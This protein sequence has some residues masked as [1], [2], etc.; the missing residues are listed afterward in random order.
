MGNIGRSLGA[1]MDIGEDPTDDDLVIE[2]V[3]AQEVIA[4]TIVEADIDLQVAAV[5]CAAL[6][7]E[8]TAATAAGRGLLLAPLI[9]EAIG[10]VRRRGNEAYPKLQ[11]HFE[12]GHA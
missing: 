9:R 10:V 4:R 2:L 5:A 3:A 7:G 6:A 8:Y 1:R 11:Q 12:A